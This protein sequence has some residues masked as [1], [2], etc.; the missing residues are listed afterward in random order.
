M[1]LLGAIAAFILVVLAP[2]V[3]IADPCTAEL[4]RR[5]GE[6]FI[7]TVRYVGDGD[8]LCVGESD[9]PATW[10]EVR[11][12]DFD[13]PELYSQGGRRSK[14]LLEEI[15]MGR[16]VNCTA[17][18]GRSGGVIVYD[19]VIA[20]CQIGGSSIGDRLRQ[21]GARAGGS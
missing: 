17:V 10:I 1:K 14:Q 11:L 13:A 21:A 5:A 15:T 2:S 12:G 8:S 4:P 9:D 6:A 7:G 18:R 16:Q 19:R 3:A 20:I